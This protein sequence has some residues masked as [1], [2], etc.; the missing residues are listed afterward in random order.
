MQ[1]PAILSDN[2]D[3]PPHFS[4]NL[5]L[6]SHVS[7]NLGE[8]PLET[9]SNSSRINA[10]LSIKPPGTTIE[11]FSGYIQLLNFL[12]NIMALGRQLDPIP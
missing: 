7:S 12:I 11:C 8:L 5:S 1:D 3:A 9:L 6:F 2:V 4:S 10:C